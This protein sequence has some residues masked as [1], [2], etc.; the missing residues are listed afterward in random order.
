[1]TRTLRKHKIT[2]RGAGSSCGPWIRLDFARLLV[3]E[4]AGGEIGGRDE[5]HHSSSFN[6]LCVA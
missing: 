2:A 3:L 6:V 1:M 4:N 5:T